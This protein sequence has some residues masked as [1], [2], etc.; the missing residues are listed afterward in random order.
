VPA[1]IGLHALCARLVEELRADACVVSRALGDVLIQVAEHVSDGG[2]LL[3]GQGHLASDY[4]LTVEVLERRRPRTV[5]TAD[6]D[7]DAAEVGLL[8]VL[9]YDALLMLPLPADGERWGL[10]EVYARG[11][12]FSE[13]DVAA[14]ERIVAARS[15]A[16]AA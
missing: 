11:R 9:G 5:S 6:P 3:L 7:A 12:P 13:P 1:P 2:T 15:G 10:V 8:R 16:V 4:P 14:A